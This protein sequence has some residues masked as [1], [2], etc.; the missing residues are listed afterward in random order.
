VALAIAP[1]VEAAVVLEV[2]RE[3]A[4]PRVAGERAQ[5]L[6]AAL[7]EDGAQPVAGGVGERRAQLDR[8]LRGVGPRL[9]NRDLRPRGDRRRRISEGRRGDRRGHGQGSKKSNARS[10]S[11]SPSRLA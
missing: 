2:V 8:R 9:E 3:D 7:A 6:I 10:A 11:P 1:D 5:V 4:A